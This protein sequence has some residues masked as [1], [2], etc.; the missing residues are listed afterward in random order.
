MTS[1]STRG[2]RITSAWVMGL[3]AALRALGIALAVCAVPA[4]AAQL[5]AGASSLSVL[6]AVLLALDAFVLGHGGALMLSTPLLQG[7]LTLTPLGLSLMFLLLAASSMRRMGRALDLVEVEGPLRPGA[8]ADAG[9]AL[10]AFTLAYAAGGALV[11]ALAR[12]DQVHPIT[13]T[14]IVGS[15]LLALLGGIAGL[16]ASIRRPARD[17]VPA[18]RVLDLLPA[19]FGA[20]ARGVAITLLGLVAAG[21]LV[22]V[23]SLLLH[24]GRAGALFDQLDPG[25]IGGL[26]LTLI[27]LA[28]LPTLALWALACLLGGSFTLGLG[29]SVSLG[30]AQ[31]GVLPALPLL[32]ALPQ[33]GTAPWWTW[34]LLALPLL[35]VGAGAWSVVREVRGRPL[36]D[37]AI[38]WGSYVLAVLVA[39]LLLLAL[40]AGGIGEGRLRELGPTASGVALPLLGMLLGVVAVLVLALDSPLVA[41]SRERIEALRARV[42][43]AE[44]AEAG[45]D[46]EPGG[47]PDAAEVPAGTVSA[48]PAEP[49]SPSSS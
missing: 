46:E 45:E 13:S 16:L 39:T 42:E 47:K 29:T 35:A 3:L 40:S 37:R 7:A 18:V 15:A 27:Q 33:P 1:S 12:S 41:A 32:G 48:C 6:S 25:V 21:L 31:V 4:L 5:T 49:R 38:A 10:G 14:A 11:A 19:P 20:V 22:V 43:R 44:A 30:S 8:L 2:D 9:R 23:G 24:L 26:V 17:G 28:L 36:R 34:L